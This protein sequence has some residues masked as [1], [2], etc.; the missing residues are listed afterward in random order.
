MFITKLAHQLAL[1]G[2]ENLYSNCLLLERPLVSPQ[3][4][5]GFKSSPLFAEPTLYKMFE[6]AAPDM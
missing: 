2:I 1:P 4:G 5:F 6:R 3:V